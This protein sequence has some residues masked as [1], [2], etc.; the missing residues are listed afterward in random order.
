[1]PW[2]DI[3]DELKRIEEEAR[4]APG[5]LEARAITT[6]VVGLVKGKEGKSHAIQAKVSVNLRRGN[7][8]TR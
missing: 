3:F 4:A 1:M 6:S 2:L 7:L 8:G 5:L